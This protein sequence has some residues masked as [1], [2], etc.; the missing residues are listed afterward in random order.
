MK[1]VCL[2]KEFMKEKDYKMG[3]SI[4]SVKE[5]FLK[6]YPDRKVL[7]GGVA[8]VLSYIVSLTLPEMDSETATYIGAAVWGLVSYF[9]PAS[10]RD[11]LRKA[12]ETLEALGEK[13]LKEKLV[14]QDQ[15]V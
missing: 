13:E 3:L 10:K 6:Y 12:D 2:N 8:G 5:K 14:A 9:V 11:L 7:M 15:K 1:D 4:T